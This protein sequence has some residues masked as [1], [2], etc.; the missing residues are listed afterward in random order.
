M[1]RKI[2]VGLDSS[3]L[4]L[5]ALQKAIASALS[6][7]AE[8]KLVHVLVDS[9]PGA[10][11][12]S[13][14]FGGPLYPSV[15][16]T[17]VESYQVAWNQFV[18]HS[19]ALLNQQIADAQNYG[20][21]AS[22]TLLYGNPG[23]RLCEVAQ[24]W[25]ADLIIVGSRGLSGMS[26][27][28]IGSVSNY[29]LH[30]A[31][32]SVLVVHAKQQPVEDTPIAR[33]NEQTDTAS[34]EGPKQILVALDKSEMAQKAMKTAIELAKLHQAEL[35]LLHVI[36]E[37]EPGL[38]QKLIFSDS[39]YISQH[40]ELLFAEYQQEWNKF[41][42][43]WWQTLQLYVEELETEGIEAIC[44]VMQGRTGQ[45]ICEVANDWPAD[46]I[47]MGCRG[48]S[49]LKELL[50]GSVSYYVSHRAPCAVFVNRPKSST[51]TKAHQEQETRQ[52]AQT[53]G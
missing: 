29:V 16:A 10:P 34:S 53:R 8:L 17:V 14:Y 28:L 35:R 51:S 6:Y 2:V 4:G 22:G 15:S 48:L 44:D 11:K 31:P 39:Q 33:K 47:V 3:D 7:N 45:Q 42:S 30:H 26:E 12:F 19:Q 37:D 38:P 25:E 52:V 23:A 21:E 20:I 13:G 24:T 27:F 46:L 32:C 1:I 50:V 9:E 18:D 5:R 49:G 41:V 43:G 36:D 40:S